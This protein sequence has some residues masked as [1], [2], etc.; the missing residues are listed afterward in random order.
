[1]QFSTSGIR[2]NQSFNLDSVTISGLEDGLLRVKYA[3]RI[4][5][6]FQINTVFKDSISGRIMNTLDPFTI[7]AAKTDGQGKAI[8]SNIDFIEIPL[9]KEFSES[10]EGANQLYVEGMFV[11]PND[12]L[13]E[14]KL[15]LDDFLD[16]R[17]I[18]EAKFDLVGGL[19]DE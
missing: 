17:F 4:P 3:N 8:E 14:I 1:M 13:D 19:N 5:I 10:L 16:M 7:K 6:S 9:S 2:F 11:T 12:G 18:L 15:Y